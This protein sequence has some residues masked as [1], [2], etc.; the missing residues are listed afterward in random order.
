MSKSNFTAII[1]AHPYDKSFNHAILRNLEEKLSA[2]HREYAVIDLYA[3][4]FNPVYR[5]EELALFSQGKYL[6]PLIENYHDILRRATQVV[7]IFPIWWGEAPAIVKGFFDKV[8]LP[9]FG[10]RIEDGRMVPGLDVD[11]TLV[12]STSEAPTE[13]F[14]TYFEGYFIPS[15]LTTIG[16]GNAKWMNCPGMTTGTLAQRQEF[17]RETAEWL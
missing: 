5:P 10:Y 12:I 14:K 9:G 1:Y 11:R 3:D 7:F 6:D 13:A 15:A 8:M 16:F 17:L 4:G 2:D